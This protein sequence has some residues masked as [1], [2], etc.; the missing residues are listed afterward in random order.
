MSWQYNLRRAEIWSNHNGTVGI[1][2]S[3]NIILNPDINEIIKKDDILILAGN[4]ELID[5]MFG[6]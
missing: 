2:R 1:I 5:K 3:K 6:E 4:N